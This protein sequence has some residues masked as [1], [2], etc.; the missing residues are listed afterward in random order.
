VAD[1][2]IVGA[3]PAGTL[4]SAELARLGVEVVVFE[5]RSTEGGGTRAIGV[6]AAALRALEASGA[7]DRILARALRVREGEARAGGRVLGTLR[8]D[9]LQ[10]RHPYVA[11][12]P[13]AET[14]AALA[15]TARLA[16]ARPVRRG[17]TVHS[18]TEHARGVD[19]RYTHAGGDVVECARL[20][21]IATGSRGRALASPAATDRTREYPDSYLMSDAPDRSGEGPRALVYLDREGV[22]ESFPLPGGMRRY[23]AWD[24]P[25]P[26]R[27]GVMEGDGEAEKVLR[28]RLRTAVARRTGSETAAQEITTTTSFGVR[29]SLVPRMRTSRVFV[30]GDAAH[31]VSPIGGQGMNLGLI[32]ATTLAPLLALWVRE[33]EAPEGGLRRWEAHRLRAAARSARIAAVNTL[34]GRPRAGPGDAVRRGLVRIMLRQ[35]AHDV[36]ARA[37]SMGFDPDA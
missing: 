14:E 3:G 36:L 1:V 32:D 28:D 30:I 31:E 4:L 15:E 18:I 24:R 16:G 10:S 33:G 17:T 37:Y 20:V 21:V 8:F 26:A 22:L 12:L 6:H 11:T 29:R 9:R 23:V 35:P 19:V 5:R 27:P 7:T 2:V 34:A 25:R 13:Q